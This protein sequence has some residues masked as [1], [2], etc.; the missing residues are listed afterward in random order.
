MP[1]EAVTLVLR[2]YDD[3]PKMGIDE[4]GEHEVDKTIVGAKW[5]G[6]FGA[7]ARERIK[8]LSLAT[9]EDHGDN[10]RAGRPYRFSPGHH[11]QASA[12]SRKFV[13]RSSEQSASAGTA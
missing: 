12:A 11:A 10:M 3:P 8:P 7:I 13:D 6:R 9:G 1:V 2:E 5:H 4:V